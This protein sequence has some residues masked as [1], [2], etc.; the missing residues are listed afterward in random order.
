MKIYADILV[1]ENC[2][3][4]F[5]L[6]T[7]TMKCIKYKCKTRKL[8]ISSFIGGFYTLVLVIPKLNILAYLPF[9]LIIAFIMIRLVYRKTN[10]ITLIKVLFIFLMTTFTLSGICFLFSIKQNLYLLGNSFKIEKYSVKYIML[11]IM[12]IYIIYNR[13]TDYVNEKLFIRNFNFKIEFEIEKKQYN[14]NGFLDTGNELVEPIT[15]LPC[16]LVEENLIKNLNF[17][18]QNTY[19]IP[20]NS[21]GY[22]GSLNGIRVNNIKITNKK[23]LSEKIDAIICPCKETLSKENEF[24]A[25]LSRGIVCK[26]DIYGKTNF[27][28]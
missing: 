28:L 18:E 22:G 10:I 2:I 20:Y 27:V 21:I 26:G 1:L 11:G 5:F 16:I 9:Q 14:F 12:I 19:R 17:H 25:L 13:I 7:L 23:C 6:L 4:N 8:I 15:N 24:N 3:V